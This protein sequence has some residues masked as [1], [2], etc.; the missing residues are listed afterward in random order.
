MLFI[1]QGLP[2][3]QIFYPPALTAQSRV[4]PDIITNF[5][6]RKTDATSLR[7]WVR[8]ETSPKEN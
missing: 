6:D 7:I 2:G 3:L 8:K 1:P 4:G 5:P